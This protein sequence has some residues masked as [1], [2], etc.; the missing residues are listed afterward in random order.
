MNNPSKIYKL[1]LTLIL[2]ILTLIILFFS[3]V[4]KQNFQSSKTIIIPTE[5]IILEPDRPDL[6]GE[7]A[8]THEQ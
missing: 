2:V 3:K 7:A 4:K 6:I 8:K 5:I 1:L